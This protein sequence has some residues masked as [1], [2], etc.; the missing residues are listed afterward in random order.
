MVPGCV[1]LG[2]DRG[3]IFGSLGSG[4]LCAAH[5]FGATGYS[6]TEGLFSTMAQNASKI[7]SAAS[8]SGSGGV[9]GWFMVAISQAQMVGWIIVMYGLRLLAKSAEPGADSRSYGKALAHIVFGALAVDLPDMYG[10]LSSIFGLTPLT[11]SC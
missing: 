4:S 2:F 6:G 3:T 9:S 10:I 1:C 11:L 7:G 8:G 5:Y